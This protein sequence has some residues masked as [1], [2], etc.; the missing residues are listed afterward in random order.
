MT[1]DKSENAAVEEPEFLILTRMPLKLRSCHKLKKQFFPGEKSVMGKWEEFSHF[2]EAQVDE[3]VSVGYYYETHKLYLF[4]K[5]L[6]SGD[7][8]EEGADIQ[9]DEPP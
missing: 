9:T 6:A 3:D 7:D 8:P 1:T 4:T 5:T 2:Q